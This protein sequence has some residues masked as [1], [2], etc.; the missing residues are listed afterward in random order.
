MSFFPWNKSNKKNKE[1][2]KEKSGDVGKFF[3]SDITQARGMANFPNLIYYETE[4]YLVLN[5]FGLYVS[6][7]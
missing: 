6:Y 4:K 1:K 7:K 3:K 5:R 2:N